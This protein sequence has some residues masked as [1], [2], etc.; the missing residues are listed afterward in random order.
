MFAKKPT[1][2]KDVRQRT[3]PKAEFLVNELFNHY[4]LKEI[5]EL[6]IHVP[7]MVQ[8]SNYPKEL[9]TY[10]LELG[11]LPDWVELDRVKAAQDIFWNYG[12]EII[13]ALLCRSLPMCYIAANGAEVLKTTAR[14]ID[15]PGNPKYERR[16]LETLQLIV[17][18]CI[19]DTT[20]QRAGIGLVS[21][22]KVRLIHGVIRRYIP[23]NEDWDHIKLGQPI[24]QEDLCITLCA[25]SYEVVKALAKMGIVLSEEERY[26]WCHMWKAVGYLLGIEEAFLPDD[27][28]SFGELS[29][30]MLSREEARSEAGLELTGSCVEFMISLLPFRILSAFS[31]SVF[32]FL[33]DEQHWYNMGLTKK[34]RFWDW[35]MPILMR[36]TLGIDQKLERSSRLYKWI[37]RGFNKWLMKKITDKEMRENRYFFLPKSLKN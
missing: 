37:I 23:E 35:F 27:F 26:N 30:D 34:H 2:P 29:K 6:F 25:F 15:H 32:K 14:L 20:L 4:N 9:E 18:I 16:L 5:N 11:D 3:D 8:K 19:D 10:F 33:N 31:Y 36:S 7:R 12:R 13:L 22:K 24:N 28:E 21:I 17:N 1:L